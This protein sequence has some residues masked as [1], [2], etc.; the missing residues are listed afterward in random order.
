[1]DHGVNS[2]TLTCLT[3]AGMAGLDSRAHAGTVRANFQPVCVCV[4]VIVC[5]LNRCVE[6][7]QLRSAWPSFH[8]TRALL[9]LPRPASRMLRGLKG[10]ESTQEK[11]RDAKTNQKKNLHAHTPRV[12]THARTPCE[13]KVAPAWRTK[14][15]GRVRREGR[16]RT[17]ERGGVCV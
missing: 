12:H 7:K 16:R 10:R 13:K 3:S 15:L 6:D 1:M 9:L 14:S 5:V 8:H 17:T 2:L 11:S 4:Y